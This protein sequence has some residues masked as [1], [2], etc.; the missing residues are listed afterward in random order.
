MPMKLQ[1]Y[2]LGKRKPGETETARQARICQMLIDE[3]NAEIDEDIKLL[4]EAHNLSRSY[5]N[6]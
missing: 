3:A 4:I 1:N 2:I 5:P 6:G